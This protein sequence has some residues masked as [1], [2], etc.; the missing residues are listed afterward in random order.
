[1]QREQKTLD[2]FG[3]NGAYDRILHGLWHLQQDSYC[4]PDVRVMREQA[5]QDVD[6][7]KKSGRR[8]QDI[9]ACMF[10]DE[11][12]GQPASFAAG[13]AAYRERF[14]EW[15]RGKS[16][17]PAD[18][19]VT[20]WEDVRPVAEPQRDAFPACTTSRSCF[21]RGPLATSWLCNGGSSKRLTGRRC[22]RS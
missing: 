12:T 18:L 13:D 22:R 10:M 17:Q 7:F 11:P 3:F 9:T 15:L 2:Y 1:M 19:L 21:G 20:S 16:L 8:L 4:R 14:R 5:Q 6:A